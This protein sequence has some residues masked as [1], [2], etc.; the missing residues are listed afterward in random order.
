M[1]CTLKFD[2]FDCTPKS[3]T[4]AI[5]VIFLISLAWHVMFKHLKA[6]CTTLLRCGWYN[7]FTLLHCIW[8]HP[9]ALHYIGYIELYFI[10]LCCFCCIGLCVH[11]TAMCLLH[12]IHC[13]AC[14]SC[15][16]GGM[17]DFIPLFHWTCST[18]LLWWWDGLLYCTAL[19]CFNVHV[20]CFRERHWTYTACTS[21]LCGG[22]VDR[23]GW[24]WHLRS[25]PPSFHS[26]AILLVIIH[27]FINLLRW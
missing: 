4:V 9:L 3:S 23:A 18:S 19:Q 10:S 5:G 16:C 15:V 20:Q 8:L 6:F 26:K 24:R 12:V 11:C 1:N 21:L 27:I 13:I 22:A 14:T 25:K 2:W 7:I 17:V